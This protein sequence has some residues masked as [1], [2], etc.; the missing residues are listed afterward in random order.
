MKGETGDVGELV[1]G[2]DGATGVKGLRG[3]Y[4]YPGAVGAAGID[5]EPGLDGLKGA[6]GIRGDPGRRILQGEQAIDI[7]V[8]WILTCIFRHFLSGEWGLPG[9]K[10]TDGKLCNYYGVVLSLFAQTRLMR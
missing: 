5:G 8:C 3:N 1:Q 10:G 6:K 7:S 4:G 9:E 2:P